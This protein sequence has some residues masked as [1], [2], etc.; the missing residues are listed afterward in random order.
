M[1]LISRSL[2]GPGHLRD[3]CH[4][5]P[6]SVSAAAADLHFR[7]RRRPLDGAHQRL[8]RNYF[9]KG[10]KEILIW[11]SPEAFNWFAA[12]KTWA[13]WRLGI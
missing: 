5:V 9:A 6:V 2:R 7:R 13:H 1:S 12:T 3:F 11:G 8:S 10:T 4:R